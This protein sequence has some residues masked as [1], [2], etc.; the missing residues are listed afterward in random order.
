M[1]QIKRDLKDL[2]IYFENKEKFD[3]YYEMYQDA[4]NSIQH[5]AHSFGRCIACG[6]IH[7]QEIYMEL[8]INHKTTFQL[9]NEK[10]CSEDYLNKR[11]R[12][13]FN[14]LYQHKDKLYP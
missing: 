8:Y 5:K 2:K 11:K 12:E 3:K 9:A 1:K 6:P 13:L 10:Y 14:Y 7:I 4:D